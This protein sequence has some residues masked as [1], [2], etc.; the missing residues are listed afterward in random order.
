[1]TTLIIRKERIG[2][3]RGFHPWVFSGAFQAIPEGIESGEA[4]IVATEQGDFLAQGY[5]LASYLIPFI[6]I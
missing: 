6:V 1:M 4:V 2:P 5:L 3:V